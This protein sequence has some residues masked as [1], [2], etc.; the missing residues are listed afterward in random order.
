MILAII[1]GFSWIILACLRIPFVESWSF[2]PDGSL[3]HWWSLVGIRLFIACLFF[4][5]AYYKGKS[6]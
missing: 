6:G 3:G 4:E 1:L 2:I 5:L